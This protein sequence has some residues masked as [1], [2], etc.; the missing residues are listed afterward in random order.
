MIYLGIDPGKKGAIAAIETNLDG[1]I[2]YIDAMPFV[3]EI[4]Y[5]HFLEDRLAFRKAVS[6]RC[7]LEKVGPHPGEGVKSSFSF[8]ENFGF[9]RGLL[10]ACKIP[11]QLVLP[12]KW[13]REF[14]LGSDKNE[15]IEVC[16][17]LFPDIDLRASE[18]SRKDHDGMAE[19]L[20]MAEYARRKFGGAP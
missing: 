12:Q 1:D 8:G 4:D 16:R 6:F 5:M 2:E 19:A 18:R 3:N 20:L 13:K 11:Y 15:S 7:C 14:S 9:I 10:V 17:R